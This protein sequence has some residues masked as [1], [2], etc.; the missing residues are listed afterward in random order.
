MCVIFL[1]EVLVNVLEKRV[2]KSIFRKRSEERR[3]G[4]DSRGED[5][6]F[7]FL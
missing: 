6:S 2:K 4:Y 1:F 3:W 5:V 7:Y